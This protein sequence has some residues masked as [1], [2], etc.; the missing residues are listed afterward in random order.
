MS[1]AREVSSAA[2]AARARTAATQSEA[3]VWALQVRA[4]PQPPTAGEGALAALRQTAA[5]LR[6]AADALDPPDLLTYLPAIHR[7]SLLAATAVMFVGVIV[8]GLALSGPAMTVVVAAHVT[9]VMACQTLYAR[10]AIRRGPRCIDVE[11]F[12]LRTTIADLS[13]EITD[14]LNALRPEHSA[15]RAEAR[16]LLQAA[17]EWVHHA[18][19]ATVPD[20]T[21]HGGPKLASDDT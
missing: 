4:W 7:R 10:W 8:A 14:L 3:A 21:A 15:Q 12:D 2:L 17:A 5:Y 16:A 6:S 11:E 20:S 1:S 13:A 19:Q 18:G 9:V